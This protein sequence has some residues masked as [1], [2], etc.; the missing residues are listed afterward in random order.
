MFGVHYTLPMGRN[1]EAY[2]QLEG[3]AS[4]GVLGLGLGLGVEAALFGALMR[5]VHFGLCFKGSIL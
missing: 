2:D 4:L 3:V 1:Q 5:T